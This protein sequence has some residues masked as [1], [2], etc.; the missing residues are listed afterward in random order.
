[1]YRNIEARSCIRFC[2]EKTIIITS[3]EFSFVALVIQ[4]AMCMRHIILSSLVYQGLL[5]VSALSH[6]R[7]NSQKKNVFRH[8]IY[9]LTF[10]TN[11]IEMFILRRIRRGTVMNVH[12]FI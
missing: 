5:Y 6:E 12:S 7:Q 10:S 9:V 11:F 3:S 8:K 1:M 4:H 2:S